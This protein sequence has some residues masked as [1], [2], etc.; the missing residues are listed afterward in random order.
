MSAPIWGTGWDAWGRQILVGVEILAVR[1]QEG[2]LGLDPLTGEQL[3][4]AAELRCDTIRWERDLWERCFASESDAVFLLERGGP[5][6]IY[7]GQEVRDVRLSPDGGTGYAISGDGE[8]LLGFEPGGA[9][10][11]C[12]ALENGTFNAPPVPLVDGSGAVVSTRAELLRLSPSGEL[13]SR[14]CAHEQGFQG[15]CAIAA[16]VPP[17]HLVLR[18]WRAGDDGGLSRYDLE[19]QTEQFLGVDVTVADVQADGGQ[20]TVLVKGSYS[21]KTALLGSRGQL[22]KLRHSR[23]LWG[24][25][26]SLP[27]GWEAQLHTC[28]RTIACADALGKVRWERP[29]PGWRELPLP[30]SDSG[31]PLLHVPFKR[32]GMSVGSFAG[33]RA[34]FLSRDGRELTL[35][36][37]AEAP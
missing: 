1:S 27:P 21:D 7:R 16:Y 14:W 3:W 37:W 5:R 36:S 24:R 19:T 18:R 9:E 13:V 20:A 31:I 34:A 26:R 28:G 12:F 25:F 33:G 10:L 17:S 22:T 23:S 11:W 32:P 6:S 4:C 15:A 30:K 2:L 8:R 35:W 29:N